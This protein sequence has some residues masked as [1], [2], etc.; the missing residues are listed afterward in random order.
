MFFVFFSDRAVQLSTAE[1]LRPPHGRRCVVHVQRVRLY[2]C[3]QDSG[4]ES[5]GALRARGFKVGG[6]FPVGARMKRQ[7]S[8]GPGGG[9][10]G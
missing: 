8:Q 6:V 7:W 9:A 10:R 1:L 2:R 5:S 3:R 4:R